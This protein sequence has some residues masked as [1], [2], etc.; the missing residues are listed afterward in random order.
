MSEKNTLKKGYGKSEPGGHLPKWFNFGPPKIPGGL[1]R[2]S[3]LL[4]LDFGLFSSFFIG[5]KWH[6]SAA[7]DPS[8]LGLM[9]LFLWHQSMAKPTKRIKKKCSR[10]AILD[11]S[12]DLEE[13]RKKTKINIFRGQRDWKAIDVFFWCFNRSTMCWCSK[14]CQPL[15]LHLF[16]AFLIDFLLCSRTNDGIE[17]KNIFQHMTQ[18]RHP[19]GQSPKVLADAYGLLPFF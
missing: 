16:A 2:M 18:G 13:E 19:S 4:V 6:N 11:R 1:G 9:A 8:E 17:Q 12:V 10:R 7:N 3:S 5:Q 15:F 14:W